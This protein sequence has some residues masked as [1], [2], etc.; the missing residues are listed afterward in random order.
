[1]E[2]TGSDS[3]S[4]YMNIEDIEKR[5]SQTT[6]SG[7]VYLNTSAQKPV[8]EAVSEGRQVR[9]GRPAAVC[10]GLLCVL[11][12]AVIT[13]LSVTHNAE[14]EQLWN[15]YNNMTV[16]RDQLLDANSNLTLE[17]KKL[18]SSYEVLTRERDALRRNLSDYGENKQLQHLHHTLTE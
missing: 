3:E 15:R 7:S 9:S 18:Q 4:I 1:M 8:S 11:L 14:R 17:R 2:D 13:G 12:L 6:I 5:A 16:E 10:L